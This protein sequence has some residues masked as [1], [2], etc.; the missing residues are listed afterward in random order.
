MAGGAEAPT[1]APPQP[2]TTTTT[3]PALPDKERRECHTIDRSDPDRAVCGFDFR[4]WGTGTGPGESN[5]SGAHSRAECI[6]KGHRH[7]QSCL[8]ME[9]LGLTG[10][11]R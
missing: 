8:A 10:G 6:A 3:E 7:C 5:H 9:D 4:N 1:V 2:G 11:R